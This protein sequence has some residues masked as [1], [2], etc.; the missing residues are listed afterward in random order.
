[1]RLV[2]SDLTLFLRSEWQN[3]HSFDIIC[4][5]G[6]FARVVIL[7]R[8]HADFARRGDDLS[9]MRFVTKSAAARGV[10][11]RV[12]TIDGRVLSFRPPAKQGGGSWLD[13][14]RLSWRGAGM[15]AAD[16]S[17]GDTI[18][19]VRVASWPTVFFVRAVRICT[20]RA[21]V[22]SVQ[23]LLLIAKIEAALTIA[24][25]CGSALRGLWAWA[26]ASVGPFDFSKERPFDFSKER[27]GSRRSRKGGGLRS[28]FRGRKRRRGEA[29]SW[30]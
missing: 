11:V 12:R 7:V 6:Q 21:F 9:C 2:R 1:M 4:Q 14:Q 16:G 29:W 26:L 8:A 19:T 30:D 20:S 27:F 3:G 25:L 18:L 22:R 24:K 10:Q 28:L 13:G 17:R 23:A 5:D 15:W